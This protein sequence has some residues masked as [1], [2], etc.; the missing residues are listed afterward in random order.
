MV[1]ADSGEVLVLNPTGTRIIELLDGKRR[2]GEVAAAIQSEYAVSAEVARRD[3]DFF[4]QTLRD[5][6]ALFT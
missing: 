3:V 6:G 1:L 4:L 5:A 2:P